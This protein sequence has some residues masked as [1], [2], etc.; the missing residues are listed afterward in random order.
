MR[1]QMFLSNQN[2][3]RDFLYPLISSRL[4]PRIYQIRRS[5]AFFLHLEKEEWTLSRIGEVPP[6]HNPAT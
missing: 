3:T 2:L 4:R 6:S 1:D 5:S